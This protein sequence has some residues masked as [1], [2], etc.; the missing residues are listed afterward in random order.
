MHEQNEEKI[1]IEEFKKVEMIVGE[2]QTVEKVPD[3]DKLLRL[4]VDL[5][6]PEP[7][8]IVSGIAGF[9]PEYEVL[10][11][12]KCVFVG[13]LAP[14]TIRGLESNGMILAAHTD[15]GAFAL[16]VPERDIAPGTRIG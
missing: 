7:R 1:S 14:R 8:Q 15:E 5:G 11:G 3:T 12:K 16:M 6:E 4:T 10:K 13:N 2:I 9:F